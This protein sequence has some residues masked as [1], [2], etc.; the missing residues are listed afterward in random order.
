MSFHLS[1]RILLAAALHAATSQ[2]ALCDAVIGLN[3]WGND[4]ENGG[5][6]A[7]AAECCAKCSGLAG[8]N[9]WTWDANEGTPP[10]GCWLK[11]SCAGQRNDSGAVSGFVA[12]PA[13]QPQQKLLP[14]FAPPV[15][16]RSVKD[17]APPA[18]TPA[19]PKSLQPATMP[20]WVMKLH[21]DRP[22]NEEEED[23]GFDD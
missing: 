2:A 1:N 7:S 17:A 10:G 13:P 14:G 21:A 11:T 18:T 6:T 22:Q 3:C 20:D 4:I 23:D 12:A 8:C 5:T 16:R 9:A 19:A 15:E